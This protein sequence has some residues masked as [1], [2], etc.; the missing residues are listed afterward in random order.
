MICKMFS[1]ILKN[2]IQEKKRNISIV[3]DDMVGV[4]ITNKKLN[5]IVTEKFNVIGNIIFLLF[6]LCDH[7]LKYQKMLD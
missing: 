5:P 3:F 7:I 2:I 1:K 6:L 4:L